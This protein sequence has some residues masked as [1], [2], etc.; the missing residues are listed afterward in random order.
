MLLPLL[1]A[2][3]AGRD[4]LLCA[5]HLFVAATTG[6]SCMW[7]RGADRIVAGAQPGAPTL[8]FTLAMR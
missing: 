2:L 3:I 4:L 1:V 5:K 7:R 6:D 8:R